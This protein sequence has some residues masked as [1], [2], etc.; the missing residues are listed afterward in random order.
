MNQLLIISR[1]KT[2]NNR[3]Y[4]YRLLRYNIMNLQLIPGE[5]LNENEI[6]Q[7]LNVSRTPVH[8]ALSLLKAEQL[9]NIVPQSGSRVSLIS[10]KN[11]R[12]GLFL[13]NTIEPPIYRQI[14]GN[15]PAKYL[16]AMNTN[17]KEVK[18]FLTA[19]PID[20]VPVHEILS[21][22]DRFHQLAYI[23]GQKTTLWTAM[24][25][26]CSHYDRIRYQG[27]VAKEENLENIYEEHKK[28][29]EF[30]LLG[31]DPSFDLE[32]FY[33]RH[34]THFKTYFSKLYNGHPDYFT[35]D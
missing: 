8:E 29:Y 12:E 13:R 35:T 15:I 1:E 4:A 7:H 28:I 23:A 18:D 17:L 10:L 33:N 11:I 2:E 30:L 27:F 22:D 5:I 25:T 6:C 34:L 19:S 26:V 14:A 24:K 16:D 20:E 9:V 3:E 31:G 21:L 32:S